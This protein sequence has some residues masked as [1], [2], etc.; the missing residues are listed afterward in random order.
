MRGGGGGQKRGGYGVSTGEKVQF[1]EGEDMVGREE[2]WGV[3]V[4]VM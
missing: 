3:F 2:L 1:E 4:S